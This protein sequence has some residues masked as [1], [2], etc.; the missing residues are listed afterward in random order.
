M[1]SFTIVFQNILATSRTVSVRKL[2]GKDMEK[3]L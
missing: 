1:K 2:N 3:G